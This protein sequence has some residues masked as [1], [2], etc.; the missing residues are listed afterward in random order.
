[1]SDNGHYVKDKWFNDL[2][3]AKK[4]RKKICQ[5]IDIA[6][7]LNRLYQ[8]SIKHNEPR[9]QQYWNRYYKWGKRIGESLNDFFLELV[10]YD[11]H[12]TKKPQLFKIDQILEEIL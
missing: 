11:G 9:G 7:E 5:C 6:Q 10:P 4:F 3:S 8:L 1:M 12:F 2:E